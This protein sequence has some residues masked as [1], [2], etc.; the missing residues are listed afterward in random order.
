MIRIGALLLANAAPASNWL[1][2]NSPSPALAR[3]FDAASLQ[4]DGDVVTFNAVFAARDFNNGTQR[5]TS[6]HIV[7][8]VRL[9]CRSWSV[10]IG[11]GR[12]QG[13]D[14]SMI[15]MDGQAQ[16][17]NEGD[18]DQWQQAC[19]RSGFGKGAATVEAFL[20]RQWPADAGHGRAW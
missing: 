1:P 17:A 19:G 16:P 20:D 7:V 14:G 8:P 4:R 3:G 9:N 6:E 13:G 18:P 2:L 10:T 11:A 12:V 15:G 5:F